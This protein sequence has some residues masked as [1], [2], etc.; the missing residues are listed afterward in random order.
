MSDKIKEL[1][2]VTLAAMKQLQEYSDNELIIIEGQTINI[3]EWIDELEDKPKN[4]ILDLIIKS[5][6]FSKNHLEN[7]LSKKISEEIKNS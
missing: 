6:S 1:E 4:T 3:Q 7:S 5:V 2:K